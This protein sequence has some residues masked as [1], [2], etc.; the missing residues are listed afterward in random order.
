M[1][2][3]KRHIANCIIGEVCNSRKAKIFQLEY[4]QDIAYYSRYANSHEWEGSYYI[5]RMPE[6][7]SENKQDVD[8]FVMEDSLGQMLCYS[9][10]RHRKN[11]DEL[12]YI[13]TMPKMS[14]YNMATRKVKYIGE[15]MLSFL[16]GLSKKKNVV[17]SVPRVAPRAK[18]KDFYYKLCKFSK[19]K[20]NSAYLEK[21]KY[22]KFMHQNEEH[23]GGKIEY[24]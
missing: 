7:F 11:T 12:E 23:T 10:I 19:G 24:I 13:E 2:F 21:N 20:D 6:I 8:H 9:S 3:Q 15:T 17:F 4:P 22:D 14:C 5:D 18:T 1:Y 16:V